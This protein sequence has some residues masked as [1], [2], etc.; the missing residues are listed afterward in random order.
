MTTVV[1]YIL[2]FIGALIIWSLVSYTL[3]YV[4]HMKFKNNLLWKTHKHHHLNK[5]EGKRT[6]PE[7]KNFFFW[8]GSWGKTGDVLILYTI[9]ALTISFLIG[10]GAYFL[11]I[12]HYIYEVFLADEALEH[13]KKIGKPIT[14]FLAIGQYHMLHHQKIIGNYSSIFVIW[15][16]LFKTEIK[17]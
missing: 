2:Q 15:D 17:H 10:G 6:L 8:F 13:N 11:I 5:Y 7:W 14:N 1:I 4:S 16:K 3:H 9:P 12:F